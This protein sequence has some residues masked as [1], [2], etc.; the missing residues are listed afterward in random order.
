[1]SWSRDRRGGR[2][3]SSAKMSSKDASS[4]SSRVG[5]AVVMRMAGAAG[6]G[7]PCQQTDWPYRWNVMV[8]A[9]KSHRTGPSVASHCVPNTTS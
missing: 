7:T 2:L 5:V 8:R 9:P 1:M 3:C 6:L 4:S